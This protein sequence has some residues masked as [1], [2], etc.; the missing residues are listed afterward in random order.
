MYS[1][2]DETLS[3]YVI[4]LYKARVLFGESREGMEKEAQVEVGRGMSEGHLDMAAICAIET[5]SDGRKVFFIQTGFGP[6]GAGRHAFTTIGQ[7]DVMV[8]H[9]EETSRGERMADFAETTRTL[10][11][12]F[13]DLETHIVGSE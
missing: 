9:A 11:E 6:G 13:K 10:E 4:G 2:P 12:F 1:A 7:Y 3:S 8:Y 5:R